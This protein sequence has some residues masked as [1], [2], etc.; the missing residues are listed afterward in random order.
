MLKEPEIQ[1]QKESK[2]YLKTLVDGLKHFKE[3]KVLKLLA[4]DS[5]SVSV[6]VFFLIWLYQPLLQSIGVPIIYFGFVH[7]GIC[8]IQI[9]F[10]NSFD[11]L[12]KVFHSKKNYLVMSAVIA[13]LGFALLSI[14]T[15]VALVII[16]L[17]IIAG[18]GFTRDVLFKSYFNKYIE[19][20]Q[21]ATVIS[22]ISM[23]RRFASGIIYPLLGLMVAVS[24]SYSF[25]ILGVIIITLALVS[26]V[27][28]GHLID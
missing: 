28:E 18:F 4:F 25:F 27:E 11:K 3:H 20:H 8:A 2:R 13:G 26:R 17:I 14:V 1:E 21:R 6:L 15:N 12:E 23:I 7:A 5:I 9:L 24:L 16:I 19:S 10:M 22:T